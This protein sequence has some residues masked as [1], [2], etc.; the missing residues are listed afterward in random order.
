MDDADLQEIE[1]FYQNLST[2]IRLHGAEH[3]GQRYVVVRLARME[4]TGPL[5]SS[6]LQRILGRIVD[7]RTWY[8]SFRQEAQE[9]EGLAE[10]FAGEGR[11]LSAADQFHRAS[12]CYHWGAYLARFGSPR[13]P[14][15]GC[16]GCA[17]T[18]RPSHCGAIAS[19]PCRSPT[20]ASRCR[21]PAPGRRRGASS[22]RGHG[23]RS[24]LGEGG[25]PQL[26]AAVRAPRAER[27]D[28]GRSRP[29]RDGRQA[30]DAT[31]GA[32]RSR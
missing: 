5:D 27:P 28:D 7:L 18:A 30:P 6:D 4:V 12:A 29:G 19:C 23:E 17:A 25:V 1:R 3:M 22:G 15:G 9:A 2:L 13:R 32:G 10:R 14:K 16:T 26:G 20:S 24:R 31:G 21:L 8:P 11:S